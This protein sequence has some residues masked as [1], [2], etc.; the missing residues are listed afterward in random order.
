MSEL[1]RLDLD[2]QEAKLLYRH[3]L[4]LDESTDDDGLRRIRR[5]LEKELFSRLSITEMETLIR[6]DESIETGQ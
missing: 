2:I 6:S 3:L 5:R 1:L 4:K